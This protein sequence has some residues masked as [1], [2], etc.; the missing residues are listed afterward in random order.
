MGLQNKSACCWLLLYFLI[1]RSIVSATGFVHPL[2]SSSARREGTAAGAVMRDRIR[3]LRGGVAKPM[4]TMA[5]PPES[6]AFV[7]LVAQLGSAYADSLSQRPILTKSVTAGIIFALSDYI[8]QRAAT[9]TAAGDANAR[10]DRTRLAVSAAVGLFYFGPAAH[11]WYN[12]MFRLF[13]A[14]NLPSTLSKAA[15]GQTLFGPTFTCIFFATGL[16]QAGQLTWPAYAQ[17]IRR[18]FP[19]TWLTGAVFW[20]TVDLLSY[21]YL[22]VPY[23]PLFVNMASLVWTT[24]LVLTSYGSDA[25]SATSPRRRT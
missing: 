17:K 11:Y 16:W 3:V 25:A 22:P 2:L 9:T 21:S 20:I 15:M 18:D 6:N 7:S 4:A 13:P 14:T 10:I 8:A 12:W 23:I 24:Y 19:R 5:S 1:G